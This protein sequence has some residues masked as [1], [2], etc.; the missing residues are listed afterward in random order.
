M[1]AVNPILENAWLWLQ[2]QLI[3]LADVCVWS[4]NWARF[5]Y[6]QWLDLSGIMFVNGHRYVY[7]THEGEKYMILADKSRG[8]AKRYPKLE[9][10]YKDQ[11]QI[12]VSLMGPKNDWHGRGDDMM[13][14]LG[15]VEKKSGDEETVST[16]NLGEIQEMAFKIASGRNDT[17]D[18]IFSRENEL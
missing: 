15:L 5:N 14:M 9:E 1:E 17:T 2:M 11:P 18:E 16:V 6:L 8:P 12:M 10:Y 13:K 4:Y 3:V 7:Y